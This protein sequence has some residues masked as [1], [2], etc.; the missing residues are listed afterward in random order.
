MQ[1]NASRQKKHRFSH[2]TAN[3]CCTQGTAEEEMDAI[4]LTSVFFG[5]ERT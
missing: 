2:P 5:E 4:D 1:Q 3:F